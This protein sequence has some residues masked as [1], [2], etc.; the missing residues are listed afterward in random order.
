MEF[1]QEG[2]EVDEFSNESRVYSQPVK[3]INVPLQF[4][5]SAFHHKLMN[6]DLLTASTTHQKDALNSGTTFNNANGHGSEVNDK[7]IGNFSLD[8][9]NRLQGMDMKLTS[10]SA[11]L[12]K[13]P[14]INFSQDQALNARGSHPYESVK[15]GGEIGLPELSEKGKDVNEC[16]IVL[17]PTLGDVIRKR[18]ILEYNNSQQEVDGKSRFLSY[19]DRLLNKGEKTYI[20]IHGFLNTFEESWIKDMQAALVKSEPTANVVAFGWPSNL[21]PQFYEVAAYRTEFAGKKLAEFILKEGIDPANVVLIGHSLGAHVAGYAG[22]AINKDK[23]ANGKL[24]SQIVGLDPAGPLFRDKG[25]LSASAAKEVIAFHTNTTNTIPLIGTL[26]L[27]RAVGHYDF[28]I[29]PGQS[30][31]GSSDAGGDHSY[32]PKLLTELLLGKSFDQGGNFGGNAFNAAT[33]YLATLD[34]NKK[35]SYDITTKGKVTDLSVDP[36]PVPPHD[37]E[38]GISGNPSDLHSGLVE[39]NLINFDHNNQRIGKLGFENADNL[40]GNLSENRLKDG[41][42][43]GANNDLQMADN[44]NFAHGNQQVGNSGIEAADKSLSNPTGSL[45]SGFLSDIKWG[46]LMPASAP[47]QVIL[48]SVTPANTSAPLSELGNADNLIE[49]DAKGLSADADT[50]LKGSMGDDSGAK[51]LTGDN[52]DSNDL[53]RGLVVDNL[54]NFDYNNQRVGNPGFASADNLV[55]SLSASR[56]NNGVMA[57]ACNDLQMA[58]NLINF[59]HGNQQVGNSGIEA[60]DKSLSNPTGSLQSGFLSDIKWGQLMPASAPAQVILG[61]VTPAYT[62][63]PLSELGNANNVQ[64]PH[65]LMNVGSDMMSGSKLVPQLN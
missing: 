65:D 11:S 58:D 32:A 44:I 31:P 33:L 48:G 23:K 19:G 52:L 50:I 24:I 40:V 49:T 1:F 36:N 9:F 39:D 17:G 63:A 20:V 7:L 60:A 28:Y 46:Q 42:T 5:G 34:V 21:D 64:Q 45:Q 16:M 37:D 13:D 25:G 56:L 51:S 8:N 2:Q 22:E 6:E 12:V 27:E 41:G 38:S 55:G 30:Q 54:L 53:R 62:S 18:K 61:S 4:D 26:G 59:A 14:L 3:R 35:G 10:Y 43:V 15:L 29:N 57:G 47:A